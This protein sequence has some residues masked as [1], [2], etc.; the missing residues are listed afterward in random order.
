MIKS[1]KAS[2]YMENLMWTNKN[3]YLSLDFIRGIAI[4]LMIIFHLFFDLNNFKFIGINIYNDP[5]WHYFRYIIITV[6]LLCVGVSLYITNHNGINFKKTL[7]RFTLLSLASIAITIATYYIFPHSWIYFGILHFIS[8]AS[9]V[10]LV[11][12][13]IPLI[14]LIVGF[15]I[16]IGWNMDILTM[17]WLFN[18]LRY[19]LHLPLRTE[20]LVP[21]TPWL[22]VVLIGIYFGA[23]KIFIFHMKESFIVKTIASFGKNSFVIYL[24]HQPILFGFIFLI[25]K[26]LN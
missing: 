9:I 25:H 10:G 14:S 16:I 8:I 17:H 18:A 4:V 26:Y 7:K 5:F 24:V 1:V 20:D 15:F 2:L 3:R 22:G 21:I 23:K 13:N 11:F 12:V 19:S 6:F